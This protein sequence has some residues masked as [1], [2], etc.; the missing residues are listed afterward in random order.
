MCEKKIDI[1]KRFSIEIQNI[2]NKLQ[3]LENGR[4]YDLTNAQMDGY[5]STHIGQLKEMISDLLYKIEYGED[6]RKEELEKSMGCI[7]L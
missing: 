2:N 1:S 4:V 3:Q 7:K 6:S 5:L